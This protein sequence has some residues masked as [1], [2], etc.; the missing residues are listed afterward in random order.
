LHQ[1]EIEAGGREVN[2]ASRITHYELGF[3]AFLDGLSFAQTLRRAFRPGGDDFFELARGYNAAEEL[4][5]ATRPRET[6]E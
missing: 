3:D 4:E 2:G 6:A 5:H 1:A